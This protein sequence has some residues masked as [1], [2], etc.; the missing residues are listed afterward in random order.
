MRWW[1]HTPLRQA[2]CRAAQAVDTRLRGNSRLQPEAA[3]Q[4]APQVGLHAFQQVA[5]K[6]TTG[7]GGV[8]QGGR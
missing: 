1:P 6:E 7:M 4:L 5:T 8:L 3:S 2:G